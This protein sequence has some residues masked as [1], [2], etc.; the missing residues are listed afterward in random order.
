MRELI[1]D[2]AAFEMLAE[3]CTEL[4]HASLKVARILRGEN[5]TPVTFDQGMKNMIEE[6]SDVI[7]CLR[8]LDIEADMEIMNEKINRFYRRWRA[9]ND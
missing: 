5:P 6:V 7:L 4:A 1:G 8:D 9:Q 2:P 3:E